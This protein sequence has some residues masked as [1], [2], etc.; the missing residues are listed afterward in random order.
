[1]LR[2]L[3]SGRYILGEEVAALERE[4]AALCRCKHAIGVASGTDALILALMALDIG[5]GHEVITT[6]YSFFATASTIVRAGARPVFVDIEPDTFN[7]DPLLVERAITQRTRAIL[8]VHLF[9]QPAAMDPLRE[10]ADRRGL[11][12]IED[13][14]QAL[15]ARYKEQPTGSLS[16]MGCFSFFPS[17][18]LG[19]IGDGGMITTSDDGLAARCRRLRVHGADTTYLHQEVGLNSRLDE[20]QAAVLRVKLPHLAEWTR[21]RRE[22]AARYDRLF[23]GSPVVNPRQRPENFS[24]FNQY[25]VRVGSRRDEMM[26]RLKELGVGHSIYYPV[27]LHLQ[28]CFADL[29][30]KPGDC[31]VAES[32]AR[33]TLA[34]P[35]FPDLTA[36]QIDEAAAALLDCLNARG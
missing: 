32:A 5:A 11:A 33:E 4:V 12:I 8:P 26:A 18:N 22:N 24:I 1:V 14:A 30:G 13:A 20:V 28:P 2:V 17:K 29:G 19:G 21:K 10:I 34:L 35:I 3:Q 16:E 36:E 6:P 15:G 25:V 31:P 9:G 23:A 27:P 7:I